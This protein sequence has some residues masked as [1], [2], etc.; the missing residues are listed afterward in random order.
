MIKP[1]IVAH[2]CNPSLQEIEAGGPEIEGHSV[3]FQGQGQHGMYEAMLQKKL[4][5]EEM[6]E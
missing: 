1:D 4:G 6:V 3:T 2:T 5:A